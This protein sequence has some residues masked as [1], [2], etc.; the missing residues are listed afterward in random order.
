M[1][2]DRI[3]KVD[4]PH[5]LSYCWASAYPGEETTGDNSTLVEFTLTA[6]AGGTRLSLAEG[7]F[8]SLVIPAHGQDYSSHE[9]HSRGWPGALTALRRYAELSAA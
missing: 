1:G 6:E 2:P 5:F 4:P 9:S 7:G 3:E 8:A